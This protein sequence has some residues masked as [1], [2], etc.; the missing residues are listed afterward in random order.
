MA[1]VKL[2]SS[3]LKARRRKRRLLIFATILLFLCILAGGVVA[4]S[5][6]P[7]LRI[8]N[9]EVL[10]VSS[11]NIKTIQ[12]ETHV[13]LGGAYFH[14]FAKDN[15]LL[16]PKDVLREDLLNT[17]PVF[18]SVGVRVKNFQT[19]QIEI[20][21]RQSQALWC[22]ESIASSSPCY[23]LDGEGIIYAPAA[24][25]SGE[26]YIKYYGPTSMTGGKRFLSA[27]EFR[28]LEA[29]DKAMASQA[30]L[31]IVSVEVMD[32]IGHMHFSNGFELIFAL[33]D[34]GAQ[35]VEHFALAMGAEPF[36]KHTLADFLYLDL[37]FGDKLYYKLK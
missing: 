29:L 16:Y 28:Q 11:V 13:V 24:D 31:S 18:N 34:D 7:F 23:L 17:F 12:D 4:L 1:R 35:L 9:V 36:I 37:R 3:R 15:I 8:Q 30:K 19:L 33:A 27:D 32:G 21:E 14:L 2:P 25:F 20:V 5:W 26:V 10:G 6:A 22:G